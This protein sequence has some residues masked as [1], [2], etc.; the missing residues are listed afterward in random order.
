MPTPPVTEVATFFLNP[1]LEGKLPASHDE[2]AKIPARQPGCTGAWV[3][4]TLEDGG[5]KL[6]FWLI[7]WTS[8]DAHSDFI[9][10]DEI[11]PMRQL[12]R[13]FLHSPGEGQPPATVFNF[14]IDEKIVTSIVSSTAHPVV[15]LL[16]CKVQAG[17]TQDFLARLKPVTEALKADCD[18]DAIAGYALE[19]ESLILL[20]IG[21][22]SEAHHLETRDARR[23]I[24]GNAGEF[25][26]P[27]GR[28]LQHVQFTKV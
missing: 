21:W 9:K 24:L 18:V 26:E 23:P 19:D 5:A 11:G 12:T 15:E 27:E 28:R 1:E 8:M 4:R 3:G 13:P 10:G 16:T 6:A 14:V 7:N 2:A 17:K 20:L 22:K 25:L